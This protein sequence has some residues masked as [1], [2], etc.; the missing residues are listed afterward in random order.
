MF[1]AFCSFIH[2]QLLR[3][4]YCWSKRIYELYYEP[5]A[6]IL[7]KSD[8][9]F[10]RG[11]T[12]LLSLWLKLHLVF[13]GRLEF[14]NEHAVL[15]VHREIGFKVCS[16]IPQLQKQ[17]QGTWIWSSCRGRLLWRQSSMAETHCNNHTHSASFLR[18]TIEEKCLFGQSCF[19][20]HSKHVEELVDG[21]ENDWQPFLQQSW[22]FCT[23]VLFSLKITVCAV[24]HGTYTWFV[25]AGSWWLG[26]VCLCVC[27][28]TAD[29]WHPLPV[30][31]PE[32]SLFG[33]KVP[34]DRRG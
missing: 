19:C 31:E 22:H 26:V 18:S 7:K 25:S 6:G 14:W 17:Q 29:C 32:S 12:V 24:L 34:A 11:T 1:V 33:K 23:V 13:L 27:E 28:Q 30:L 16:E 2:R 9:M 5:F 21:S 3:S 4:V 20:T 15:N 8:S 10:T